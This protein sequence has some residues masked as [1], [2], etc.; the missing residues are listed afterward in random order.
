MSKQ[1]GP[2]PHF[3]AADATSKLRVIF[4][5]I[6]EVETIIRYVSHQKFQLQ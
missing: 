2:P 5:I 6:S 1:T 3:S 4:R